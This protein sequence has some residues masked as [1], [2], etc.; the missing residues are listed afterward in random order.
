MTS[1]DLPLTRIQFFLTPP[2]PC[3]Y[4]AGREARSM[5]AAPSDAIDATVY[6]ELINMGFRR[7]GHH[8]YRPHCD[9]CRACVPVR[10]P[11]DEFAPNRSQRR[12]WERNRNLTADILELQFQEEHYRLYRRYQA[13]RHAGGG[14]DQDDREQYSQFLLHSHVESFL[15]EFRENGEL[16]MVSLVD[17]VRQGLSAVYTFYDPDYPKA[18]YGVHN[19]LWQ[20]ALC[21]ELGLPY[22][23]LGYWIA[24]SR[25]M[26]YKIGYRPLEGLV[27]GM[28]QT[29]QPPL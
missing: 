20:L 22:L 14:M 18:G 1:R 26:S 3:S 7:S 13:S 2:Y 25:K 23:Y 17:R 4:L 15:V 5:V 12:T 27:D 19:I 29:L 16:R 9:A 10:I 6:G 24:E 21:R 28:W 11:V 8:T